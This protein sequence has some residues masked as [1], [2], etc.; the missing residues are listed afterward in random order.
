MIIALYKYGDDNTKELYKE[1]KDNRDELLNMIALL[2]LSYEIVDDKVN[3]PTKEK[4]T[5]I[6]FITKCTKK[7]CTHEERVITDILKNT[8][9][10]T[11]NYYNY[12]HKQ[13][14][15]LELINKDFKGKTFSD[16]VWDNGEEI[17]KE[18]EKKINRFCNGE[19]N[20]SKI[21]SEINKTYNKG[22]YNTK[23]LVDTEVSN[24]MNNAFMRFCKETDVKH[25]K[26]NA[27]L[28]SRT[29][30]DCM[31]E[32]GKVYELRNAPMIPKHPFVDASMRLWISLIEA[33]LLNNPKF[34]TGSCR[35]TV[36]RPILFIMQKII[37]R[38]DVNDRNMERYRRI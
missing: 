2:L 1:Q 28:D 21:K 36:I 4:A 15:V 23:R 17:A 16:R 12:N 9:N 26:R 18:L 5:I 14:D 27:T 30:E 3:I 24:C 20:V 22:A 37:G 11:W 8:V 6:A 10:N 32:D 31:D 19:I 34:W 35:E 29:C 7:Q 38:T 13:K 25:I 33:I